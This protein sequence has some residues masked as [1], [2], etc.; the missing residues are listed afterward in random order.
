MRPAIA[1]DARAPRVFDP[2]IWEKDGAYYS[3]SG[4]TQRGPDGKPVRANFLLRSEDLV[5]WEYRHPF[6]E[7]DRF[8]MVGDDGACPY[9]WLIGSRHVLLFFSQISG[10]QYLLGNYD[11]PRDKFL[12]TAHG[13]FNFGPHARGA[14]TRHRPRPTAKAASLSSST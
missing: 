10:G 13:M 14:Y 9:F 6:V 5:A 8:T 3:L 12:A 7:G 2:C 4:G 1:A 11:K